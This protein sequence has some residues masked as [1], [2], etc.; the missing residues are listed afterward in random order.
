MNAS[1]S[2]GRPRSGLSI[3]ELWSGAARLLAR[4]WP[5]QAVAY[6]IALI[7][8]AVVFLIFGAMIGAV[9]GSVGSTDE[10]VVVLLVTLLVMWMAV[11]AAAAPYL[12]VRAA[13]TDDMTRGRTVSWSRV[14]AD[15]LPKIG[16]LV[17]YLLVQAVAVAALSWLVLLIG[18][19]AGTAETVIVAMV[20]GVPAGVVMV[21]LFDL[22]PWVIVCEG[23]SAPRAI[24]RSFQLA[25][26]SFWRI[27]G[28]HLAW[29]IVV[30]PLLII[31]DSVGGFG[32]FVLFA[33]LIA[34]VVPFFSSFLG[35]LY[36][37]LRAQEE[38]SR[39]SIDFPQPVLKA[40]DAAVAFGRTTP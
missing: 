21:I 27:V 28:L 26:R 14:V 5:L 18:S 40:T 19:A 23:L 29:M 34:V 3:V 32:Q 31:G 16:A 10:G 12:G 30:G 24:R 39:L 36:A 20:V 9:G 7:C 25:G 22:G 17:G 35:V 6:L 2:G 33:F 1:D 38:G 11:H 8:S 13:V 37:D 4:T 15:V